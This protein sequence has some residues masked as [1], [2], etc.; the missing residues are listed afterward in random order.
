MVRIPFDLGFL[1]HFASLNLSNFYVSDIL[2]T[3]AMSIFMISISWFVAGVL[4]MSIILPLVL[5]ALVPITFMYAGLLYYYRMTGIDMQRLDAKARS[6][7]QALVSEG[8]CILSG[9]LKHFAGIASYILFSFGG[10]V[11]DSCFPQ[12]EDFCRKISGRCG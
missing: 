1:Q 8:E 10:C 3:E 4:V 7:V 6:P 2:L 5:C 11:L 9:I 12:R